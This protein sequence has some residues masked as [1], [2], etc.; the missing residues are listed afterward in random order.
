MTA[1]SAPSRLTVDARRALAL[2]AGDDLDAAAA[3]SARELVEDC[4]HCRGHFES[5]RDGLDALRR[6]EPLEPAAGLWPAVREGLTIAS[7]AAEPAPARPWMPAFA[8]TAAAL[9]VGAF[10][11]APNAGQVLP[12]EWF[13]PDPV[14]RPAGRTSPPSD[15]PHYKRFPASPRADGAGYRRGDDRVRLSA[16][17]APGVRYPR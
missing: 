7:P 10:A 6:S 16:P 14:V 17:P 12:A 4:P 2:L 1:P 15:E 5:V 9:L 13:G 3:G 11:F 8:V